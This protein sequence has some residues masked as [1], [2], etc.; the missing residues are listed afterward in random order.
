MGREHFLAGIAGYRPDLGYSV[1]DDHCLAGFPGY[2]KPIAILPS[3]TVDAVFTSKGMLV[4]RD[5]RGEINALQISDYGPIYKAAVAAAN[6]KF[7]KTEVKSFVTGKPMKT[8]S[9]IMGRH[10]ALPAVE[11]RDRSSPSSDRKVDNGEDETP[12]MVIGQDAYMKDGNGVD[13]MNP[14]VSNATISNGVMSVGSISTGRLRGGTISADKLTDLKAQTGDLSKEGFEKFAANMVQG[15]I[16]PLISQV[17]RL[18]KM[19]VE[20]ASKV[21]ELEK[22]ISRT[23]EAAP[24]SVAALPDDMPIRE[25]AWGEQGGLK[26][27]L[28]EQDNPFC[29]R[30][31]R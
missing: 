15:Y 17:Q 14:V 2:G 6:H 8:F 3:N 21:K 26:N 19:N 7:D 18:A 31:R 24:T 13:M 10:A 1:M 23:P 22:Q 16:A 4:Y 20:L 27:F 25:V 28:H 29:G 5:S 9:Q 11:Q 30:Y 12:R